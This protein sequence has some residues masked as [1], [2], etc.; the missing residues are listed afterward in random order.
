VP[1]D[2]TVY[3]GATNDVRLT[4]D[5]WSSLGMAHFLLGGA[6]EQFDRRLFGSS[7]VAWHAGSRPLPFDGYPV[8]GPLWQDNV[9]VLSGTYRDGF[10]C[11]PVLARH[12][13]DT[14]L[15]GHGVLGHDMFAPLRAPLRTATRAEAVEE[16]VLH[17]VSQ[18]YQYSPRLAPWMRV[19][20]GV[21][22]QVRSRTEASYRELDSDFGLAPELLELLNWGE[23]R[24][25]TV[26]TFRRYLHVA[27]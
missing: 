20:D 14:L 10:H 1:G 12:T 13:A 16:M 5:A 27:R 3:L 24:K 4:A 6:M 11:A 9:Q 2:G 17:C 18:F 7:V 26:A 23:Q 8:I 22:A 21:E 19:T 15:G 25:R